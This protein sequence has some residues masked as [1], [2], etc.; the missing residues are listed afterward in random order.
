MCLW[1]EFV[2]YFHQKSP[3]IYSS[4]FTLL[5]SQYK[6]IILHSFCGLA[7]WS[8]CFSCC[9]FK[10]SSNKSSY[11][12]HDTLKYTFVSWNNAFVGVMEWVIVK[13]CFVPSF[14][15]L[16]RY[17]SF[18]FTNPTNSLSLLESK[19]TSFEIF[20]VNYY[21]NNIFIEPK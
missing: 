5:F 20:Y 7:K 4:S 21:L 18:I 3:T 9:Q 10:K 6:E 11:D 1:N 12:S 14:S 2:K 8:T 15:V 19:W 13:I 16:F 17:D